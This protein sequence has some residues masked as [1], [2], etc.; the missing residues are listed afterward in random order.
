MEGID[1]VTPVK[2]LLECIVRNLVGF[3]I[4]P[5]FDFDFDFASNRGKRWYR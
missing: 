1:R 2:R 4:L 5:D 3:G